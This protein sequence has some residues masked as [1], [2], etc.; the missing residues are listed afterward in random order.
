MAKDASLT[1]R[2]ESGL[3]EWLEATARA[4]DRSVAGFVAR[5][6]KEER[7]RRMMA[8]QKKAP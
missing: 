4:E 8:E 6:I 2:L 1:I 3:K 7:F 5:L